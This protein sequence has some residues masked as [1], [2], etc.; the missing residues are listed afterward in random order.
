MRSS[1]ELIS[2]FESFVA[3]HGIDIDQG[4][5]LGVG[6]LAAVHESQGFAVR[7]LSPALARSKPERVR[8]LV[9]EYVDNLLPGLGIPNLEQIRTASLDKGKTISVAI[10]G[11]SGLQAMPWDLEKLEE[12]SLSTLLD[13]VELADARAIRFDG[14]WR[15][16]NP[17]GNIIFEEYIN[18]VDY[19]NDQASQTPQTLPQKLSI[20]ANTILSL[21]NANTPPIDGLATH[22]QDYAVPVARKLATECRQ[23]YGTHSK[24]ARAVS[25]VLYRWD[26]RVSLGATTP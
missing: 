21:G 4:L 20:V 14:P 15:W 10:P 7:S 3:D 19:C 6:G 22:T 1:V 26:Q 8:T 12:N 24:V 11:K 23:R 9:V 5:S 25:S 17:S 2:G 13:T 16:D 18:F